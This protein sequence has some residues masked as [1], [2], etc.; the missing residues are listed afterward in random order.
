MLAVSGHALRL[1]GGSRHICTRQRCPDHEH[2]ALHASWLSAVGRSDSEGASEAG[3]HE[4]APGQEPLEDPSPTEA[5]P[6]QV[7]AAARGAMATNSL[8]C[9]KQIRF[10]MLACQ[11]VLRPCQARLWLGQTPTHLSPAHLPGLELGLVIAPQSRYI[12]G[13]ALGC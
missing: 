8:V 6:D 2:C 13:C 4:R 11:P 9:P 12:C 1:A 3:R 7:Q 10:G 5:C